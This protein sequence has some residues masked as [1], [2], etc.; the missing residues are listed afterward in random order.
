MSTPARQC[1]HARFTF[2]T[3]D[4]SDAQCASC[5]TK[6]SIRFVA[7]GLTPLEQQLLSSVEDLLAY[8][9][10]VLS[11]REQLACFKPGVVQAHVKAAHDAIEAATADIEHAIFTT[12]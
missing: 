7:D 3:E 8:A 4:W 1:R 6:G 10:D 5:G 2:A 9:E 12:G 11:S